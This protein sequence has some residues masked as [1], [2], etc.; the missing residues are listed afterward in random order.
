MF[1]AKNFQLHIAEH[2]FHQEESN[3]KE[4]DFFAECVNDNNNQL[5]FDDSKKNYSTVEKVR[6]RS[7]Y[8]SYFTKLLSFLC[9]IHFGS[10][11][12]CVCK[13]EGVHFNLSLFENF[14]IYATMASWT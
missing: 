2:N 9:L 6:P 8:Y 1:F 13:S 4:T 7:T 5:T 14:L 11:Y 10:I 12:L 3:K